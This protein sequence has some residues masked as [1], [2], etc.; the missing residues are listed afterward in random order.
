[1]SSNSRSKSRHRSKSKSF[2]G[3][4]I[5]YVGGGEGP[6]D[7]NPHHTS[8]RKAVTFADSSYHVS[9]G[10]KYPGSSYRKASPSVNQKY[11][12]MRSGYSP[13]MASSISSSFIT[14]KPGESSHKRRD[15]SSRRRRFDPR[16]SRDPHATS[17]SSFTMSNTAE[18][19]LRRYQVKNDKVV[20]FY[21][22]VLGDIRGVIK[23][24][25]SQI[26]KY[27]QT[28]HETAITAKH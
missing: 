6:Y 24:E 14:D 11:S 10:S 5:A 28:K 15:S 9:Q 17:M 27:L 19:D 2:G 7:E 25:R 12:P 3:D 23:Q 21:K 26:Q 16:A 18:R 20:G 1:M 22:K 8:Q 4:H 13:N